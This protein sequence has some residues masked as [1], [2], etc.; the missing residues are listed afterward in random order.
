MTTYTTVIGISDR[1]YLNNKPMVHLENLL[2][3][4]SIDYTAGTLRIYV[5]SR[6]CTIYPVEIVIETARLAVFSIHKFVNMEHFYLWKN[7]ME[8]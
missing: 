2:R 6:S 8:A 4:N 1:V 3:L 7:K 5:Q